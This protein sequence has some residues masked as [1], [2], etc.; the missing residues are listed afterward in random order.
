[1][2]TNSSESLLVEVSE[3]R[4]I[5]GVG[6][7]PPGTGMRMLCSGFA[8]DGWS[9][10]PSDPRFSCEICHSPY[11]IQM[12]EKFQFSWSLC[13]ACP[14]VSQCVEL[15]ILIFMLVMLCSMWPLLDQKMMS[16][17]VQP[18]LG[19]ASTDRFVLGALFFITII[20]V[21]FT[22][23]KVLQRW[24]SANSRIKISAAPAVDISENHPPFLPSNTPAIEQ[25]L[26]LI[27]SS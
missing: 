22:I 23:R 4:H 26:P 12:Q 18:G 16:G 10:M 27:Q 13:C 3:D 24:W 19:S 6:P 15:F 5:H 14:S 20:L 2:A 1:M 7:A 8:A 21:F 11:R 9:P 25:Q 17:E